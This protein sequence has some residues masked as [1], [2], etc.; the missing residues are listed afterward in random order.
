[1]ALGAKM[2]PFGGYLMPIQYSGI[3]KEH[4][5][6][7]RQAAIFDTC[8]MGEFRISG[9]S[10]A[11]DLEQI[12]SCPVASV[13]IGQ[14]RYGF[15]CNERGGVQDDQILYR[16]ADNEFFMVVNAST[17]PADFQWIRERLSAGTRIENLSRETAKLD[18]QGPASVRIMRKL[19]ALP[20]DTMKYYAWAKNRYRGAEVLI[21]RTGYTGEI[22][23]EIYAGHDLARAFWN[24]CLEAGALP[25]GL[26]CRDTLRLEMGFPLY[27]H[28][29]DE[30]TNAA[31]SGFTRAIDANK[32]FIGSNVVLDPSKKQRLLMGITVEGRRAAR[33]GDQVLDSNGRPSG[34][35]TSGSFAPSLGCAVALGYVSLA[36]AAAGTRVKIKTERQEL[37]GVVAELPFYKQ[38]TGRADISTFL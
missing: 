24:D 13:K 9:P 26:G 37:E 12:L 21:S 14:C 17:E 15:I 22:G 18:L 28:E 8:H 38:A 3:I 1:V 5:A 6:A 2:A 10:A 34:V 30:N 33:N 35:V 23:F 20:I 29:L 36:D 27:G 11:S 25:A 7:R 16:M 4:T 32:K 19:M 31:E